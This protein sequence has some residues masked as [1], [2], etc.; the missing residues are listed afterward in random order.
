MCRCG[1]FGQGLVGMVV[2]GWRLDLM[3]LEVFSNLNDSMIL[4]AAGRLRNMIIPLCSALIRLNLETMVSF[5]PAPHHSNKK[6]WTIRVIT[7]EDHRD[8]WELEHQLC[9]KSLRGLVFFILEKR[10]LQG[11]Y[12]EPLSACK[13]MMM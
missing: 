13:Q 5:R 9:K 2:M 4:C 10:S 11:T 12:Q 7:A 8:G 1:T 6:C 3:I